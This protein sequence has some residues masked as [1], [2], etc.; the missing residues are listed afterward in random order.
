MTPSSSSVHMPSHLRPFHWKAR[1]FRGTVASILV[2]VLSMSFTEVTHAAS[3][4]AISSKKLQGIW[5]IVKYELYNPEMKKFEDHT[6]DDVQP[7]MQYILFQKDQ[8]CASQSLPKNRCDDS[9]F[10]PFSIEGNI[11]T[12]GKDSST[13]TLKGGKLVLLPILPD[14]TKIRVTLKKVK[15]KSKR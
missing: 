11:L 7:R 14:D 3:S 4:K 8:G 5:K 10:E 1:L 13:I 9:P 15:K 2:I 12:I 6:M